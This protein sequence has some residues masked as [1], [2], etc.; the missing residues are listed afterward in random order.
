MD[1][2]LRHLQQRFEA[3]VTDVTQR[4]IDGEAAY[5]VEPTMFEVLEPLVR[6]NLRAIID[7][8]GGGEDDPVPAERVGSVKAKATRLPIESVLHGYRIA[9]VTLWEEIVESGIEAPEELPRLARQ[10][11]VKID[12]DSTTATAA[13]L[14][15]KAELGEAVG[16]RGPDQNVPDMLSPLDALEADER[17]AL[18]DTLVTWFRERGSTTATAARLHYH[19]NT[20]IKRFAHLEEI[21]GRSVS[22]PRGAADLY[23]ALRQRGLLELE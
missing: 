15:T 21:T 17:R 18:L 11:W 16:A 8:L 4:I 2:V 1:S 10:L 3:I 6:A 14:T 23:I 5:R 20:I 19:R 12:R 7:M 9:G 13:F 22:D